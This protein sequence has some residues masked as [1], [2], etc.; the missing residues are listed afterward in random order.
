MTI[1]G[2]NGLLYTL[3]FKRQ[4]DKDTGVI[5][6]EPTIEIYRS[7]GSD[8]DVAVDS[9][10]AA[11]GELAYYANN[12]G[13]LQCVNLNTLTPVWAVDLGADTDAALALDGAGDQVALYALSLADENGFGHVRRLDAL[14][15]E[16]AWDITVSGDIKA[17]PL[18]GVQGLAD[19]LI[20][21]A[22]DEQA[23]YA[24]DKNTGAVV[25]ER[26]V[27]ARPSSPIAL[28]TAEGVGY[29]AVGDSTGL[30]L[31][32]GLTGEELH[33]L[34][35]EGGVVGSPAAFDEMILLSSDD[36][37]LHALRVK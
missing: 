35:I 2:G 20:I 16:V 34:A 33:F 5:G 23:V 22:E 3:T 10:L 13:I 9:A 19:L 32:D 25:W 7:Q 27:Q 30:Y 29:V 26:P 31:L 14:T 28:Y 4:I 12:G 36:G 24:L 18:V 21:A 11:Y 37:Q 15:G 8:E 1:V 17:A 6:V